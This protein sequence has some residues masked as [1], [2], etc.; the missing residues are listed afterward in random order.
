M[1]SEILKSNVNENIKEHEFSLCDI[2]KRCRIYLEIGNE[3]EV[4]GEMGEVEGED[5]EVEDE[6]GGVDG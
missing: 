6:D 5:G 2:A 1:E 4:E 3:E